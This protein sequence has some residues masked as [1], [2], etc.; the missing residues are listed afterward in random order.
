MTAAPATT[1]PVPMTAHAYDTPYLELDLDAAVTQLSALSRMLPATAVHYAVKAN[2]HPAL[3]ARLA[4]AGARF[5]VASPAEVDACVSAGAAAGDLLY[6]N[7]VKRRCDIAYAHRI[8]VR[9]YVID[10]VSEMLKVA[11]EAPGSTVLC[12]LM[13]SGGGTD[14]PL[15][16]KFGASAED[17]VAILDQAPAVGLEAG[18]V[19]FHVG[20]QQRD[21]ES[22][23]GPIVQSGTI[24]QQLRR[25]GHRPWLLDLGGGFPADHVGDHPRLDWYGD[26]IGRHLTDVFG[27]ELPTTM[28][29]PGRA[30]VGD[31]GVLVSS[32][33][34]VCWRGGRRWVYLDAGV[35]S[36]LMETLGESIHYRISADRPGRLGPVVLAGPT[37]DSVDV[38][39]E[40][41]PIRL[42][43]DLTEGDIVRFRSAG[44]YTTCYSTVGF[45]GFA[46]LPTRIVG[47]LS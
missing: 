26:A 22:W 29:E 43:L 21:P 20:S 3:L 36:G 12:R 42:P 17:C 46:P 8:G 14:W 16:R 34:G 15:S 27:D 40:R 28:I 23:R 41:T 44:A 1:D 25:R 30:I 11:A 10:C 7:P 37:C 39:Y 32:V 2:P 24:F 19:A 47:P 4:R 9:T 18:G 45:N 6:S 38:L 13:T 31:A 35:F 5:D 33:V